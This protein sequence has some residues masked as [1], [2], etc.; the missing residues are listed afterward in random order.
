MTMFQGSEPVTIAPRLPARRSVRAPNL[1]GLALV[2][3][4]TVTVPDAALATY[5]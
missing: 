2:I 5:A 1:R 3:L 4:I